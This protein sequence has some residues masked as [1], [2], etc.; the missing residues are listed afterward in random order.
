[1]RAKICLGVHG[2][3]H[4]L[5]AMIIDFYNNCHSSDMLIGLLLLSM[6]E[7][8]EKKWESKETNFLFGKSFTE[9]YAHL[10]LHSRC[11]EHSTSLSAAE[12]PPERKE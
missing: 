7:Q 10:A 8:M 9:L 1:M 5:L 2:L 11:N 4:P 12:A 3:L 6:R